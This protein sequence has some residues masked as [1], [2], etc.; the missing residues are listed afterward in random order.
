M[1][2]FDHIIDECVSEKAATIAPEAKKSMYIESFEALNT[3]IESRLSRRKA[4]FVFID[5]YDKS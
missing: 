5:C 2:S 4:R 3:W 1:Y